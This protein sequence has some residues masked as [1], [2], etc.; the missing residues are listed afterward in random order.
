[1]EDKALEILRLM[2]GRR[3]MD[4]KTERVMTEDLDRTNVYTI[5]N[6]VVIFS[7]KDKILERDVSNFM[8]FA[9]NNGYTN[10]VV[11][12]SLSPSSLNV[13]KSVKAQSK[14]R[15]QFFHIRELQF[16]IMAHRMA[17]PHR[18]L[19]DDEKKVVFDYYKVSKPDEQIPWIDSQ[20]PMAKWVGAFPGD[21]VEVT[22]HSDSVGR[23][24]YYRYCVEDVNVAV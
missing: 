23:S 4:T 5:G 8:K 2:F 21:V 11:I 13:L 1:M 3:K 16:D 18:I 10:G 20:D 9:E 15:V 24:L 22:R 12:V 6:V 19:T 17:M 7:Q 14:N